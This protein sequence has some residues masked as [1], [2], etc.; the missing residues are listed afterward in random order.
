MELTN[1]E[2]AEATY[3]ALQARKKKRAITLNDETNESI[4][5]NCKNSNK[6]GQF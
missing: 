3:K 6:Q 4:K 5:R 1:R 2:K